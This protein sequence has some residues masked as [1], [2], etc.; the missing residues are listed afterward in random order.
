MLYT[1][2]SKLYYS[3]KDNYEKIYSSRYNSE[4]SCH[5]DIDINGNPAFLI[6]TSELFHLMYN[7][8]E[9]DKKLTALA[10]NLPDMALIQYSKKC[11][12]DEI[13]ITNDIEG[14][15]STRNEINETLI[16][17]FDSEKKEKKRF[18]GLV[19]KYYLLLKNEE[20][21]LKSSQDIRN[22]YNDFILTEIKDEDENNVPDGLYF[23]KGHVSVISKTGKI[24]HN[25]V[26]PETKIVNMMEQSLSVLNNESYNFLV[27]IAIFHYLFAYIHPFYDGNGRMTRFISSYFLTRNLHYLTGFRLSYTIKE[28]I[29]NYYGSFKLTNDPKNK[30]DL[31]PFVINFFKIIST[32]IQDLYESLRKR[33]EQLN[34]YIGCI[35]K[36]AFEGTPESG[37]LK[38]LII[39]TLF[40]DDGL[41]INDLIEITSSSSS[42]IRAI[43]KTLRNKDIL[44]IKKNNH[45]YVYDV[46]LKKI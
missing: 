41:S 7:I 22:L 14:V 12:V 5:F 20:I 30:G 19:Q 1:P 43:I 24:I 34:F 10:E 6:F 9:T 16:S 11:L 8:M 17:S 40:G 32:L 25:G 4:S 27:R 21:S 23:R 37:V 42:K 3:D 35:K 29:N 26:Y 46:D 2:L 15:V 31:T 39:N 44:I 28:N 33:E 13:L 36:Y 38:I 45:K 18:Y